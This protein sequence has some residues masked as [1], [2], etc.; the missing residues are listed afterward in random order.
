MV[1]LNQILASN[2][3]AD[4]NVI[5]DE[6]VDKFMQARGENILNTSLLKPEKNSPRLALRRAL[7]KVMITVIITFSPIIEK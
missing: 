7:L 1:D 6:G 2:R 5:G 4:L 3:I